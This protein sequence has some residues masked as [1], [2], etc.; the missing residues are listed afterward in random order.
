MSEDQVMQDAELIER[1]Q[2]ILNDEADFDAVLL[3]ELLDRFR[4]YRRQVLPRES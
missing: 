3:T 1:V 4:D 2:A